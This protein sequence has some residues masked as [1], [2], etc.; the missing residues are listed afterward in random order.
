MTEPKSNTSIIKRITAVLPGMMVVG[1]C[2]FWCFATVAAVV[3]GVFG[4]MGG[5][6][7][8][9]IA[10]CAAFLAFGM[11]RFLFYA[12]NAQESWAALPCALSAILLCVSGM[13]ISLLTGTFLPDEVEYRSLN[14]EGYKLLYWFAFFPLVMLWSLRLVKVIEHAVFFRILSQNP[15]PESPKRRPLVQFIRQNWRYDLITTLSFYFILTAS[16]FALIVIDPPLP[17][18]EKHLSYENFRYHAKFPKDGYDFCYWRTNSGL[19][20]DFSISEEGFQDWVK[21]NADWKIST[22]Q[23]DRLDNGVV[24]IAHPR[25]KESFEVNDG[26]VADQKRDVSG[27]I[28]EQAVFDRNTNRVYYHYFNY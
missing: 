3:D 28:Y 20:C 4:S 2:W 18:F 26:L 15:P 19:Y 16:G 6:I 24:T 22:I 12:D 25:L 23:P 11:V 14:L 21:A 10:P 7:M 9:I 27:G 8:L 5:M 1:V 17:V 13:S